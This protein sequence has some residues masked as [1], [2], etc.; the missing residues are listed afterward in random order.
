VGCI[1]I[2]GSVP[3]AE[4][5]AYVTEFQEKDSVKAAVVWHFEL[6]LT[7]YEVFSCCEFE[8]VKIQFY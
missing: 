3:T 8:I 2:D 5:E 7:L 6:F 1:R 4:R